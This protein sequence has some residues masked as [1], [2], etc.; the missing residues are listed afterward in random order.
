M[1]IRPIITAVLVVSTLAAEAAVQKT[2]RSRQKFNVAAG[3]TFVLD[4][5]TGNVQITGTDKAATEA[6][7]TRTIVGEDADAVEEGRRNTKYL[8]GGDEKTCVARTVITG[9]TKKWEANV[10]WQVNVPRNVAVRIVS[11]TSEIIVRD[12]LGNIYVQNVNG[13]VVL[14]N[15]NAGAV[16]ESANGSIIYNTTQPH[17]DARLTS[18]NGNITATLAPGADFR[19]VA[20]S[21]KGD[22]RTNFP[23]RGAFI[24]TS[25]RANV[26][27]PGG[28]VLQTMSITGNINLLTTGASPQQAHS[29]K[30]PLRSDVIESSMVSTAGAA[31]AKPQFANG[32]YKYATNI[33][34]VRIPEIP[35]NAEILTGAGKVQLGAVAG[36]ARVTSYGG[37]L[38]FGEVM[39]TINATTRAGDILV[40]SARRGGVL[41]TRGGTIRLLYTS[42]P[43]RLES[44]G[45]DVIVRQAAAPIQA[46]TRSG[47]IS[48]TVD[49]SVKT[50]KINA[51]TMKGNIVLNVPARF[52]ADIEATIET[53]D[54]N[55]DTIESELAGLTISRQPIEGGR[56]RIRATGKLNGGGERVTLVAVGGDI[57]I[58]TAAIGPTVVAPK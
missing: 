16:V 20:E 36:S 38:Q 24:N 35:G 21:L 55:A 41:S 6:V 2:F 51:S 32:V 22:I 37:P 50:E 48:I 28:P 14:E 43:T 10:V 8:I 52:A 25:F 49:P 44:G 3:G 39:G 11:R 4:N 57:R 19:W 29:L 46:E 17:G 9:R 40:D 7:V 27:A 12:V 5:A 31:P 1:I 45:G 47:D 42:G 15:V 56:T 58:T 18:I 54:A 13:T 30:R 53:L 23:A 26:N 34:D 33:G